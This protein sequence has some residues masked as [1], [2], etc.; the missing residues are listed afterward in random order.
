MQQVR[1][2]QA[3]LNPSSAGFNRAKLWQS[4]VIFGFSVRNPAESR[5]KPI[6]SDALVL[7]PQVLSAGKSFRKRRRDQFFD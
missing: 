1:E 4:V 2:F 3:N 6:S 7:A 5:A